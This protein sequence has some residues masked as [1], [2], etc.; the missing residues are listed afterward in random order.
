MDC[1]CP[2]DDDEEDEVAVVGWGGGGWGEG[3]A[4]DEDAFVLA[5]ARD[6]VT[7]EWPKIHK[8]ISKYKI[9]L[10][11]LQGKFDRRIFYQLGKND[12]ILDIQY[13]LAKTTNFSKYLGISAGNLT[14]WD[15][16]WQ[17]MHALY[18]I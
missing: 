16:I 8:T 4:D 10:T 17:N 18:K 15:T 13:K 1:V 12:K 7:L 11:L 9:I 14:R 6:A 2:P 5:V 3:A